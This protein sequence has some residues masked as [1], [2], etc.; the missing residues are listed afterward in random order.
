[1]SEENAGSRGPD[2]LRWLV[3]AALLVACIVAYFVYAP[4]VR[5]PLAPTTTEP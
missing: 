2:A 1:M 4:E 3:V 5:P